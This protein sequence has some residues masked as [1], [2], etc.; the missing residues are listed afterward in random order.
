MA[1]RPHWIPSVKLDSIYTQHL[2]ARRLCSV[3]SSLSFLDEMGRVR[4]P[5]C[6]MRELK[7]GTW[8]E[9]EDRLLVAHILK[10]GHENWRALPKLAGM[11]NF[12][13]P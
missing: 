9:A 10:Y 7:R 8:N 11:I 3:E 2:S 1:Q 5:C 6:D 12:I 4:A 13:F